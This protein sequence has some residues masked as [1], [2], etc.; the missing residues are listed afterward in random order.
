MNNK[1]IL[2]KKIKS[3]YEMLQTCRLLHSRKQWKRK[4]IKRGAEVRELRKT[5]KRKNEQITGLKSKQMDCQEG[6]DNGDTVKKS[7]R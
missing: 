6:Q 3:L 5:L 1:H 7:L 2:L 4:A